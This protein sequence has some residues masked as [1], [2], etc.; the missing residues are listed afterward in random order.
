MAESKYGPIPEEVFSQSED[1]WTQYRGN[2]HCGA[3]KFN[4][5]I[6]PSFPQHLV[7]ACNCS[8]CTRNGYLFVYP[9]RDYFQML[10]GK[11]NLKAYE[12]NRHRATHFFCTTCGS[13][14]YFDFKGNEPRDMLGVNV[15]PQLFRVRI[16]DA[17]VRGVT[18]SQ[19]IDIDASFKQVRMLQDVDLDRLDY[20]FS[21]GSRLLP[22]E[23][24][25]HERK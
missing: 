3:V 13:S 9:L 5:T 19:G 10:S 12:F 20:R 17:T 16:V 7:L 14:V 1:D 18:L 6:S 22:G 24:K 8:I 23:Y 11:D 25:S 21:D 4:V 15:S 2:C